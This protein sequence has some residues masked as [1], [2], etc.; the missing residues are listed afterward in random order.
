[1]NTFQKLA[2]AGLT[3]LVG[4]TLAASPA[5]AAPAEKPAKGNSVSAAAK[6]KGE[7]ESNKAAAH[8]HA[9]GQKK[10][11]PVKEAPVE[12]APVE[13]AP[14]EE[15]PPVTDAPDAGSD[16]HNWYPINP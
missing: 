4:I 14:V 12:E 1:M 13:E 2:V 16:E 6:V 3:G 9:P 11:A 10:K 5:M 15:A 8:A 7:G